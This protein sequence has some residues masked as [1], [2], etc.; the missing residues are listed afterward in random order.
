MGFRTVGTCANLVE[1]ELFLQEVKI[2]QM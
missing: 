2:Q 1:V